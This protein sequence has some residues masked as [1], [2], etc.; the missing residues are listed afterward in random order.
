[1]S[2]LKE[3]TSPRYMTS[4]RVCEDRLVCFPICTWLK[5]Y[6]DN[7]L[8]DVKNSFT[9]FGVFGDVFSTEVAL[10]FRCS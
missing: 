7:I 3:K 9:I 6:F 5:W 2:F 1:M 4:A 8:R 10:L